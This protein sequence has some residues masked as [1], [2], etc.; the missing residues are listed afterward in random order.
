M[1]NIDR[2]DIL[3][4]IVANGDRNW[5]ILDYLVAY[6]KLCPDTYRNTRAHP[7][8]LELCWEHNQRYKLR[9]L[10]G[11]CY[12]KVELA[13]IARYCRCNTDWD[14]VLNHKQVYEDYTNHMSAYG[15]PRRSPWSLLHRMLNS[16]LAIRPHKK[17]APEAVKQALTAVPTARY[18]T[19][20]K[21]QRFLAVAEQ[22]CPILDKL[23][24]PSDVDNAVQL[25]R[26]GRFA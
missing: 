2:K 8:A 22:L 1:R 7:V 12:T 14:L 24:T 13:W 26:M 16:T 6:T 17:A 5:T 20:S 19:K 4:S 11:K 25:Y 23:D 9:S 10:R 15:G 21:M 3:R 18:T